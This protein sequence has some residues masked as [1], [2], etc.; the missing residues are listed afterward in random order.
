MT[1]FTQKGSRSLECLGYAQIPS[2]LFRYPESSRLARTREQL[3][4]AEREAKIF[5]RSPQ[6]G[7]CVVLKHCSAHLICEGPQ[8]SDETNEPTDLSS[9]ASSLEFKCWHCLSSWAQNSPW[10][11]SGLITC[12]KGDLRIISET[13][14]KGRGFN[15]SKR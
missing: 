5:D 1:F 10:S 8:G 7:F 15:Y 13:K 14:L 6:R 11:K 12:L 9:P 4:P 2:I 3:S